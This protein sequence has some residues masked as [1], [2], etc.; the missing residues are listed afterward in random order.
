MILETKTLNLVEVQRCLLRENLV[1]RQ[2]RYWLIRPV[3]NLVEGQAGFTGIDHETSG[4]RLEL[5]GQVVLCVSHK[6][7]PILP[8]HIY[9]VLIEHIFLGVLSHGEPERLAHDIVKWNN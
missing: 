5:P 3:I 4:R 7:Y 1:N 8:K 9:L 6:G 2:A